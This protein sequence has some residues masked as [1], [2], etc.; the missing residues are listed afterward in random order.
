MDLFFAQCGTLLSQNM[1]ALLSLPVAG[2]VGSLTHCSAMCGPLVASQMLEIKERRGAQ[3]HVLA[4]HAGRITTY[5]LLGMTA[6]SAGQLLFSSSLSLLAHACM[7]LAGGLFIFSAVKPRKTHHCCPARTR[8]LRRI[9]D[10]VPSILMSRYLHGLL[11][12]FMPCGMVVAALLLVATV[13]TA[14]HA[15]LGMALFGLATTPI[16][17]LAGYGA[18]QLQKRYPHTAT[19]AGRSLMAANGMFLCGVGLNFVT[20]S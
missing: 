11:M 3:H 12:G 16:L 4:Y 20:I 5:M 8:T 13:P 17:Q 10:A 18:L 7:L 19:I 9:I 1:P 6:V 14:A 2:M 15:A